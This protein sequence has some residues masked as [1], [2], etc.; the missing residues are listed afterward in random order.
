MSRYALL[1]F[2]L[3]SS[4]RA[5]RIFLVTANTSAF[6][7][8]NGYINLQYNPGG[9]DADAGTVT[10]TSFT[11]P[12][13]YG[14]AVA[15]P[16]VTGTLPGTV[17]INN[18][19]GFNDLF[20]EAQFTNSL[21]F[22]VTF[23]GDAVNSPNPAALS[24]SS[25]GFALYAADQTTLL[26]AGGSQGFPL[27]VNVGPNGVI[28]LDEPPTRGVTFTEV[29]IPEPGFLP[30]MAGLLACTLAYAARRKSKTR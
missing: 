8:A 26:I 1:A 25:F 29:D 5:D 27:F 20:Q 23:G 15:T 21:Q 11:G 3:A 13:S 6:N 28:A 30:S 24:G 10:I 17:V 18:S 4:L 2:L 7:L 14:A 12:S 19:T 9:G 16:T 22:L